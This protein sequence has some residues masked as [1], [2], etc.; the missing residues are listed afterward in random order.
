[1]E[2][3][4]ISKGYDKSSGKKLVERYYRIRDLSLCD[5]ENEDNKIIDLEQNKEEILVTSQP[6]PQSEPINEN[7]KQEILIGFL[8]LCFVLTII[9]LKKHKKIK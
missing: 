6:Q 7:L 8:R 9:L 1:M 2:P 3:Y 5:D 4:V